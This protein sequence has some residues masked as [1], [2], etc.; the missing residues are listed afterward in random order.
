MGRI[1]TGWHDRGIPADN[2]TTIPC[3]SLV[4]RTV[5]DILNIF[6]PSLLYLGQNALLWMPVIYLLVRYLH[7]DKTES[8]VRNSQSAFFALW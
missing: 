7:Y 5:A 3:L 8:W 4:F 1:Y 2:G 6:H